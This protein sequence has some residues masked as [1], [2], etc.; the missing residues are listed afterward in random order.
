MAFCQHHKITNRRHFV[1]ITKCLNVM[2]R[3]FRL[4]FL[5]TSQMLKSH[6]KH[7]FRR[8]FVNISEVFRQHFVNIKQ[9]MFRRHFVNITKCLKSHATTCFRLH[10]VNI[11][12]FL[13]SI[14]L[15]TNATTNHSSV[16]VSAQRRKPI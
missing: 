14:L 12:S 4:H 13:S 16:G 8:H 15:T 6:A 5:L 3:F 10:F 9:K 2:Q 11:K 1:N 7:I